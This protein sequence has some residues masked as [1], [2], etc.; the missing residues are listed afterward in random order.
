[1][2]AAGETSFEIAGRALESRLILGTALVIAG[3]AIV[4]AR[5]NLRWRVVR[6]TA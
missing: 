4:N 5:L 2:S 1:M 6:P 3:I